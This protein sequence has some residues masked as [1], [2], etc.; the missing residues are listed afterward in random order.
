MP[1]FLWRR[2]LGWSSGEDGAVAAGARQQDSQ[3]DRDQHEEDRAPGGELGKQVGCAARSE[4]RLRTLTAEGASQVSRLALLQQNHSDEEETDDDVNGNQEIDHWNALRPQ[5]NW[6]AAVRSEE[7]RVG[8][9]WEA[10]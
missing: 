10:R 5:K 7:R 6:D 9:E 2:L 3:R 4:R 1:L 8:K